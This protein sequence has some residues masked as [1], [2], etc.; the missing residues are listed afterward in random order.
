MTRTLSGGL[1]PPV[2]SSP[3]LASLMTPSLA[4][5]KITSRRCVQ[6]RCHPPDL[7]MCRSSLSRSPQHRSAVD[8]H[9][10]S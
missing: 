1:T 6:A 9:P 4:W 5:L 2:I 10:R 3:A 7:R 8:R